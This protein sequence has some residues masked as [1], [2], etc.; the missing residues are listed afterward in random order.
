MRI[1]LMKMEIIKAYPG[2]K[3]REEVETMH[4]AQ[5][6][7]IYNNLRKKGK[8]PKGK[9]PIKVSQEPQQLSLDDIFPNGYLIG[10][11]LARDEAAVS[12]GSDCS[13]NVPERLDNIYKYYNVHIDAQNAIRNLLREILGIE[14]PSELRREDTDFYKENKYF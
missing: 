7:A 13:I 14:S 9:G 5:I 12:K 11:D 6:A 1:D 8:L 10:I 3:W 4:D 2:S